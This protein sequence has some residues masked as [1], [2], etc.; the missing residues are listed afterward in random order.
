MNKFPMVGK[1]GES[2]GAER[3]AAPFTERTDG[4]RIPRTPYLP[5][6]NPGGGPVTVNQ[7]LCEPDMALVWKIVDLCRTIENLD[8]QL[9]EVKAKLSKKNAV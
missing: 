8:A 6:H 4:L 2:P 3:P 1:G 9:A 5:H 7:D